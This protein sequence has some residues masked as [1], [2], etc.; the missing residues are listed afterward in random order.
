MLFG[1]ACHSYDYDGWMSR[2]DDK[3]SQVTSPPEV[4]RDW[5]RHHPVA[6]LGDLRR[7]L[8]ASGRTVFRALKEVGYHSSYS[9][10]GRHY[11]LRGI[12]AFD[13][14][15]LWFHRDVGFSELG[16]LRATVEHMVKTAP[17]GLTHEEL[18]AVLR[19]R[20]H[21]TLRELVQSGVVAREQVDALYVYMDTVPEV[22][23]VQLAA[24]Q[25]RPAA[26]AE[27]PLPLL[28]SARVIDVL[29][30]VI[31]DP[32]T[33]PLSVAAVLRAR[34]FGVT[35]TQVEEVFTRYELQKKRALSPSRR[36]RH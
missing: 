35:N 28:D 10:A 20:V 14:R 2:N 19:L 18:K 34:G 1:L 31:R 17:A 9:H 21:D 22:A 25:Q 15:G 29:L 4:L 16:T 33:N 12:P 24:R 7:V 23:E 30:T 3:E 5:F 27:A 26:S 13:P 6:V 8:R 32:R 36:S 11:T